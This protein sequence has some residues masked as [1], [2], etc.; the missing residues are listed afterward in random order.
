MATTRATPE[1]IAALPRWAR[2][3]IQ[4][5]EADL[6]SAHARMSAGPEASDTFAHPYSAAPTPLGRGAQVRFGKYGRGYVVRLDEE[7]QLEVQ[8]DDVCSIYPSA[9]NLFRI[10][11]EERF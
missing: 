1:R 7:G 9:S 11:V 5:L 3:Y 2:F 10:S 6:A 4:K 8:D